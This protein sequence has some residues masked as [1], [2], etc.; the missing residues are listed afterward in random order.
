MRAM[1]ELRRDLSSN[2]I[3]VQEERICSSRDADAS[4]LI[5]A[6]GMGTAASGSIRRIWRTE[7]PGLR[8]FSG[9]ERFLNSEIFDRQ[10][11]EGCRQ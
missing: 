8:T 10:R 3:A 5:R 7:M 1:P 2:D 4:G 9:A 6:V 11:G